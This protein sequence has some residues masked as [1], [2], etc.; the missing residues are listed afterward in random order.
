MAGPLL[1]NLDFLAA[2]GKSADEVDGI[3][4]LLRNMSSDIDPILKSAN[5]DDLDAFLKKGASSQDPNVAKLF[6][7]DDFKEVLNRVRQRTVFQTEFEQAAKGSSPVDVQKLMSK[8][9]LQAD[10]PVVQVAKE[11][12]SARAASRAVDDRIKRLEERDVL[13]FTGGFNRLLHRAANN[14][15]P[16]K[17]VVLV[18]GKGLLYSTAIIGIGGTALTVAGV[19]HLAT[20]GESTKALTRFAES[21]AT[22]MYHGIKDIAPDLAEKLKEKTPEMTRLVFTAA[23]LQTDMLFTS[24][25]EMNSRHNMGISDKDLES[26]AHVMEGNFVMGALRQAGV[27]IK[28]ED[29]ERVMRE[30]MTAPDRKAYI[31]QEFSKITGRSKEDLLGVM[32]SPEVMDVTG[33]TPEQIRERFGQTAAIGG[34]SAGTGLSG[35][36]ADAAKRGRDKVSDVAQYSVDQATEL[37][38]LKNLSGEGLTSEFNKVVENKGLN[39]LNTPTLLFVKLLDFI[40]NPFGLGDM[41]KRNIVINET[42]SQFGD[43]FNILKGREP[44]LALDTAPS[45]AQ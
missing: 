31:A 42:I 25:R 18:G 36:M 24:L 21:A 6:A 40:G 33:M 41:F 2:V 37:M 8:H 20:D 22:S 15:G 19:S 17:G 10:D 9:G 3:R 43:K 32:A 1:K 44:Q 16:F 27:D 7:R 28:G 45:V 13:N 29:V 11:Y 5:V 23:T 38:R 14:A 34:A 26:V 39:I 30:S 35:K 12:E 4:A